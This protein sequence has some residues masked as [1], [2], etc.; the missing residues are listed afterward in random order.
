MKRS[1][2][3]WFIHVFILYNLPETIWITDT[4]FRDGQQ[5]TQM[6]FWRMS[7]FAIPLILISFWNVQWWLRSTKDL[8]RQ[9]LQ[10]ESILII[11]WRVWKSGKTR[12]AD[13]WGEALDQWCIWGGQNGGHQQ[14]WDWTT[15]EKKLLLQVFISLVW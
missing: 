9:E 11:I 8:E 4:T 10:H 3:Y 12:S 15:G 2:K 13:S 5:S 1:L 6:V 14:R 7:R